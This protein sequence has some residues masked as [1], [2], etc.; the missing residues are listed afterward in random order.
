MDVFEKAR[1]RF[2]LPAEE[3]QQLTQ[4]M[5]ASILLTTLAAIV[6]SV[7]LEWLKG[8]DLLQAATGG[9]AAGVAE[10]L[11][12]DWPASL[13]M[14]AALAVLMLAVNRLVETVAQRTEKGRA[15]VIEMRQG[16]S[17][18]MPRLPLWKEA[19]L[20]IGVGCAEE[21]AFR[22]ALIGVFMAP[23]VEV[24]G[25]PGAAVL[26]VAASTLVFTLMHR[27]YRDPYATGTI[28]L[29]GVILGTAYVLAGALTAV[30]VAHTLYDFI[31]M[32]KEARRMATDP[33]YFGVG[34]EAPVNAVQE[35]YDR[36]TKGRGE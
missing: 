29:L 18:E 35:E 26:A 23:G 31:L 7:I 24:L 21:T 34:S 20:M 16:I 1:E 19:G 30:I 8:M 15:A 2:P 11:K 27:Q 4:I 6:G 22:Y 12:V 13:A 3:E 25:F 10:A 14:G 33:D 9:W 5:L 28:V 17:G 36:L 32:V